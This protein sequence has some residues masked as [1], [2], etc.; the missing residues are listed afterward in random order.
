MGFVDTELRDDHGRWSPG[1]T[2]GHAIAEAVA[3]DKGK[4]KGRLHGKI[5]L[6]PG[7][8][9]R[10]SGR[11]EGSNDSTVHV[12]NLDRAGQH[13]VRLGVGSNGYGDPE[14]GYGRWTANLDDTHQR[15]GEIQALRERHASLRQALEDA[16]D[17]QEDHAQDA[18]DEFEQDNYA[19]LNPDE[20]QTGHTFAMD[21]D[22]TAR[23]K[24]TLTHLRALGA[25]NDKLANRLYDDAD[26]IR[27]PAEQ[28]AAWDS[29]AGRVSAGPLAVG[30]LPAAGGALHYRLEMDDPTTGTELG[31]QY[32]PDG[33]TLADLERDDSAASLGMADL[34]KLV[35]L[36]SDGPGGDV[37]DGGTMALKWTYDPNQSRSHGQFASGTGQSTVNPGLNGA[38]RQKPVN[39]AAA[40]VA[41]PQDTLPVSRVR[42][43]ADGGGGGKSGGGGKGGRKKKAVKKP[44]PKKTTLS[45]KKPT[46][47]PEPSTTP[48][49]S[50][51]ATAA[52]AASATNANPGT[53]T[54]VSHHATAQTAAADRRAGSMAHAAA[55]H[56]HAE[57]Q[58][59][60]QA[61]ANPSTV[62]AT[63]KQ[64]DAAVAAMRKK[65]GLPESM[66]GQSP[67]RQHAA[68]LMTSATRQL[69]TAHAAQ[70]TAAGRLKAAEGQADPGHTAGAKA[71]VDSRIAT[72]RAQLA[73]ANAR[74]KAAQAQ[75]NA[76][77][78]AWGE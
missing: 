36:L 2:V 4:D 48:H 25:T 12:A 18:L 21:A 9:L 29:I 7:E 17:Q 27:D 14:T 60:R 32:V 20:K 28:Q 43:H 78:K 31:L 69:V 22:Q 75:F 47:K 54:T 8:Q 68:S 51:A 64:R 10:S 63:S 70:A 19:D 6:N 37:A 35:K 26:D 55:A 53:T 58:A 24:E 1:G 73:A 45:A 74:I 46:G 15:S 11:I 3:P 56:Q 42:L 77:R 61:L 39:A 5:R 59:V 16:D 50:E 38:A 41:A 65:Y 72:A 57:I 49:G 62:A 67:E 34:G 66:H 40:R 52:P 44:A 71:Y 23:L 33:K 30:H 13:T 76:G